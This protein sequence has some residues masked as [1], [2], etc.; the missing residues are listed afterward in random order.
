[1]DREIDYA[2]YEREMDNF[3]GAFGWLLAHGDPER[4]VR[5]AAF[6][7]WGRLGR[8]DEATR[9]QHEALR[10]LPQ[11]ST[12]AQAKLLTSVSFTSWGRGELAEARMQ[13]ERA[14]ALARELGD[15]RTEASSLFSLSVVAGMSGDT[16]ARQSYTAEAETVFRKLGLE[17]AVLQLHHNDGLWSIVAGD[18]A[19]ARAQLEGV[20]EGARALGFKDS[21]CN[22]LCDLGV[23]ALYERRFDEAVQLFAE[24]LELARQ[25]AWHV[26]IAWTV[27]GLGCALASRGEL[28][29]AACL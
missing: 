23:N 27:N 22:A 14:L 28:D 11:A 25:R 8:L 17:A 7:P 4:L 26:N 15:R 3:R 10:H 2:R 12:A 19:Q 5:L 16:V 29:V 6:I 9:A 21:S 1:S 24:S 18:Y 13:G 20:L